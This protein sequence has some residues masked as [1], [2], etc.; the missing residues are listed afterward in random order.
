MVVRVDEQFDVPPPAGGGEGVEVGDDA[1]RLE[2]D[3]RHEHRGGAIVDGTGQA[4]GQGVRRRRRHPHDVDARFAQ[5]GELPAQSVELA[6]RCHEPRSLAGEVEA[7]EEAD[8]QVV[9]AGAE[10]DLAA[11]VVQQA[12]EPGAH[13]VGLRERALPLVVDAFCGV[14]ER[15]ELAVAGDI[16]PGLVRVPGQ[17]QAIGHAKAR[18]VRGQ[19]VGRGRQACQR[20]HSSLRMAHRSGNTGVDRVVRR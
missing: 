16:R 2:E 3:G 6:V 4:L 15:L 11:R 8:H 12:A 5:P 14:V 9:R 13:L 17:Q 7:G 18:V 10:R 19:G 1:R 20:D